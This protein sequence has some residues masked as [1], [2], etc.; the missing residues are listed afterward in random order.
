LISSFD[1][2]L[3]LFVVSKV[4]KLYSSLVKNATFKWNIKT[5]YH[6]HQQWS[7]FAHDQYVRALL[8]FRVQHQGEHTM[9]LFKYIFKGK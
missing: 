1:G 4:S 5:L 2:L 7:S 9:G 3:V 6:I 8:K